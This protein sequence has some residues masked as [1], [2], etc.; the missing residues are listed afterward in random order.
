MTLSYGS[1]PSPISVDTLVQETLRFGAITVDSPHF[2]YLEGRP[3]EKGRSVLMQGS[4]KGAHKE[5]LPKTFNVKTKAHEYGGKCFLAHHK[6]LYFVNGEDQDIY[7]YSLTN[8]GV[9]RLTHEPNLRFADFAISLDGS[10]LYAVAEEHQQGKVT[11]MLIRLC[12]RSSQLKILHNHYDFYAAPRISPN[13]KHL[14][15]ICW[16]HPNMPWDATKLWRGELHPTEGLI[17]IRQV[18]GEQEE[19]ILFPQWSSENILHCASDRTGFWNIYLE[20]QGS[21]C[22]LHTAHID[23]GEPHWVFGVERYCFLKDG[24]ILAIGT[25][26]AQDALYHI[27]PNTASSERLPLPL[28]YISDLYLLEDTLLFKGASPHTPISIFSLNLPSKTLTQIKSS[29]PQPLDPAYISLPQPIAFPSEHKKISYGFYYPPTHPSYQAPSK[30][31]PPLILRCHGGPTAHVFPRFNLETLYFTSR[32]FAVF[33]INYSGSSGYG[34]EYRNRLRGQWGILDVQDCL[35]AAHYLCAHELADN[36]KLII[37]GSSAGGFTTLCA[38]TFSNV[39]HAGASYYGISDLEALMK[40]THKMEKH[41]L[42][43]LIGPYPED[44]ALYKERSPI[45]HTE[46]LQ[47]PI[48]FFQGGKDPV[49]SRAQSEHMYEALKKKHIPSAY[50]L[51]EEESHGFTRS[52]TIKTCFAAELL[53]YSKIFKISL[54]PE[55]LHLPRVQ[56]GSLHSSGINFS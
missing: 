27:D 43:R 11:N 55:D 28:T 21:M 42:D 46:H 3:S 51:F 14:A 39:F 30:T 7:E 1:W 25:K 23:F 12:L 6:K 20:K 54:N 53:F 33:E 10:F 26:Q 24:S 36:T 19:S 41:Y 37:K 16:N 29:G 8:G 9:R 49:V 40:D 50:L 31:A 45:H 15:W 34:R 18:A 38:M 44:K 32:G 56:E 4:L 35:H 48:I 13:G 5:L 2:Y 17:H 52:E 22:P 47:H